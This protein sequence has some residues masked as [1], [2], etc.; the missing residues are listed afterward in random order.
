MFDD[1]PLEGPNTD[2]FQ[3]FREGQTYTVSTRDGS[4]TT[5][6]FQ[7]ATRVDR[8]IIFIFL[9]EDNSLHRIVSGQI[10]K[11]VEKCDG[12]AKGTAN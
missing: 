5:G 11:W 7:G 3:I 8:S 2:S 9:A 4:S 1:Q 6:K 10:S 12:T